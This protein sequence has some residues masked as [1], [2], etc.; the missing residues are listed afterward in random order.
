MKGG[1]IQCLISTTL[2]YSN[3]PGQ[4][5]RDFTGKQFPKGQSV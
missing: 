5:D 2:I 4:A 1:Y 3:S